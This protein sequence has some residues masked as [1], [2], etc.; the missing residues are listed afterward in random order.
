MLTLF[1]VK[2]ADVIFTS[3][4]EIRRH[5]GPKH[6]IIYSSSLV[7]ASEA[8]QLIFAQIICFTTWFSAKQQQC[9]TYSM[10]T[11]H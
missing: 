9:K 1:D 3:R 10:L 6:Y 8:T 7:V 11:L 2:I 4:Q 5:A